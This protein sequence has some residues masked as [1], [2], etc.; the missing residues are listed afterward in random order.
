MNWLEKLFGKKEKSQDLSQPGSNANGP[1]KAGPRK[2]SAFEGM[3]IQFGRYSDNNKSQMKTQSWYVAEDRYKE[4]RYTEALSRFFE[5]LRDDD[6]QN[7]AVQQE[8]DK[9]TFTILQGSKKVHGSVHDGVITATS[10]LAIMETPTTAVM[11]RLLEMNYSLYYCHSAMDADNTLCMVFLSDISA[12]N[13]SKLYYGLRELAT[14]ADR[15]DDLLLTDFPQLKPTDEEHIVPLSEHE[16]EV[17]YK[18]F[19]MWIEEALKRVS[20]LN[21][22]SFSGAIA[23]LLLTLIYRIDFLILPEA[24]LLAEIEKINS[25]YWEKKEEITLVER[26]Q[27]MKEAIRKLLNISKE[28]FSKSLYHSKSTFSIATPPKSDKVKDH[29]YSANKDSRWYTENKYP[30][31]AL[32]INEYGLVY[33]QFIYSMPRVQTDLI[34]IYMA[35]MH[36]DYFAELGMKQRLYDPV[37]KEFNKDAIN[38]ACEQAIGKFTDKFKSIKWDAE[39]ISYKSLYEFG[40][41]FSEQLSNLNLETKR[42]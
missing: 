40:I 31:I 39:R 1:E 25:L 12:T 9:F 4:K 28:E 21:A 34:T 19:R 32:T 35:V 22:D 15:Q 24:K 36:A 33:N 7:V 38:E 5:Y 26:N 29:V 18:Y 13:P 14:K 27:M 10:P 3:N 6:A 17:K 37:K 2:I 23:Y 30:E 8:G 16:L 20:D 11:R 42:E 41:D